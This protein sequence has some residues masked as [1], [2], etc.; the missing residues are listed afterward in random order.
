MVMA[1]RVNEPQESNIGSSNTV[2][3]ASAPVRA[4]AHCAPDALHSVTVLNDL[5][6]GRRAIQKNSPPIV[7]MAD[8]NHHGASEC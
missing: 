5:T 1:L 6:S 2:H 4:M 3:D 8:R 7:G